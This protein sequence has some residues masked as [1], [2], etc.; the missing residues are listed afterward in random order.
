MTRRI[1]VS[2]ARSRFLSKPRLRPASCTGWKVMPRTHSYS[3]AWRVISPTSWSLTPFFTTTT[4]VVESPA[5]SRLAKAPAAHAAQ[6]GAADVLQ[7]LLAQGIELQI[8]LEPRPQL[9]QSL[10]EGRLIGEAHAIGVQHEMADRTL[11]R[12]PQDLEDLGMER[13]LAAADLQQIGLALARHQ[14]IQHGLDLGQAAI[15]G[16]VRGGI[17]RS[18]PGR[19][20][21][22]SR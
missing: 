8:D 6:I 16:P 15:A 11:L 17:R 2:I 13:G 21:C 22:R 12:Q 7:R 20:N 10:D 18:R 19:S 1:S 9:R 3:R 14:R 5:F 4:R